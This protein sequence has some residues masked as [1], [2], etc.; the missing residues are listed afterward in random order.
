MY[1]SLQFSRSLLNNYHA[2]SRVWGE[3]K[4]SKIILYQS[5]Q[6]GFWFMLLDHLPSLKLKMFLIFFFFLLGL[7]YIEMMQDLLRS[8]QNFIHC[9][10]LWSEQYLD[11]SSLENLQSRLH[12]KFEK[13]DSK[14]N[15]KL[16]IF[17]AELFH[18]WWI[19]NVNGGS[20]WF[21]PP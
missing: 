15:F 8:F 9:W 21:L 17:K 13:P 16:K 20:C 7:W 2:W 14:L 1:Y 4:T 5:L 19:S 11:R 18:K 6:G 12:D 10:L 3:G